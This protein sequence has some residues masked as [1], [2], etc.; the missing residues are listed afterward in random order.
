LT[1]SDANINT[2]A[3]LV[4]TMGCNLRDLAQPETLELNSLSG[5]RV[6]VDAFLTAFQF[7]T[8]IRDRSPEGDGGP[9]KSSNGKVVSHLMGFL[10]RT[11]TLLAAGIKPV[12]IF[13]GKAPELKA[14]EIA[15]RKA[16]RE[17]ARAI[18]QQALDAGDFALAQKMAQRIISY[19]PEMVEETKQLLDLLG[20]P[21][22]DAKAEGEGQGAVMASLG[23]RDA[24]A[25]QDWDA[26]LYGT[27]V[28][29]RN[30]MTAGNK[31]HGRVVKAQKIIL[32]DLLSEHQ[33][34]REQLIDL[35]IMIGTDFHP[36]IKGI[37]P[38]TGM[39]LIKQFGNIETICEEKGKEVPERLDEIREI[40]HNHPSNAVPNEE[41]QLGQVDLDGLK[42]FLQVDRQFSQRRM[43]NAI[44][45]L[46]E[47]GLVRESGQTSLFSF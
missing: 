39:K 8:T 33:L 26:L 41:L 4:L 13:D 37:G 22:V 18:H 5:Q 47:A 9:L 40:F 32:D 44:D 15:M 45:K 36:G 6:G 38:K 1:K 35:A 7:L 19:T 2:L 29:I 31:S 3:A 16:R 12:F 11:T 34:T 17:E 10:N 46:K 20:V 27:P 30:M 24:V 14:D 28:M 42:Q 21:W 25:T 43:D 23:Q